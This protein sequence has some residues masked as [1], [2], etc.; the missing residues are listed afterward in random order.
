MANWEPEQQFFDRSTPLPYREAGAVLNV[1]PLHVQTVVRGWTGH[2]GNAVVTALDEVMWDESAN[3]PK[4]FPR[5]AR[6]LNRDPRSP[7]AQATHLHPLRERVLRDIRL[8]R[9]PRP[10]GFLPWGDERSRGLPSAHALRA[11]VEGGV[12]AP[13][14]G[15]RDPRRPGEGSKTEGT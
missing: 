11:H 14:P 15:R 6:L 3:G 8:G 4:P 9:R 7:A 13:P 5:T 12:G 2:L 10:F 1:S